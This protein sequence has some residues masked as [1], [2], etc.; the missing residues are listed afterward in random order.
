MN[1]TQALATTRRF[2]LVAGLGPV[3]LAAC[4]G[5]GGGTGV[6]PVPVPNPGP[7]APGPTTP[8]DY[9]VGI[10]VLAANVGDVSDLSVDA[11]G[12]V[13]V[14]RAE[15]FTGPTMAR[16]FAFDGTPLPYGPQGQGL[17]IPGSAPLGGTANTLLGVAF[18]SAGNLYAANVVHEFG[19]LNFS[20]L[21]GGSISRIAP[22]GQV[23]TLVNWPPGSPGA[24]APG[25]IAIG[26][27]G[28]LYFLD[29]RT[30]KLVKWAAQ[31]GAVALAQVRP[32]LG[33]AFGISRK[34]ISIA[35]DQTNK[36]YVL[37]RF[38]LKRLENGVMVVVGE[39]VTFSTPFSLAA[40]TTGNLY[41]ADGTNL[42]FVIYKV[43][44]QGVV[45]TVAGTWASGPL[46]PGPLPGR[47]G[48]P[49]SPI[50]IGADGV[51]RLVVDADDDYQTTSDRALIA[52]RLP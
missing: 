39:N 43:S 18:D 1:P 48:G 29:W 38:Q 17:A 32:A 3:L 27:D 44:P 28:V 41:V 10:S 14:V 8:P 37:D 15:S 19:G 24:M 49:L 13:I 16:K 5:G 11:Q 2:V 34:S 35:V 30:G 21:T 47:L 36:V 40:D 22:D 26:P 4:G 9:P 23:T 7:P 6:D 50:A 12:N 45:S 51:L 46:L 31:G 25:S 42:G 20:T 52:V 33:N